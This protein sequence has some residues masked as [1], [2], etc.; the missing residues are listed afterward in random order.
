VRGGSKTITELIRVFLP[1]AAASGARRPSV[2]SS[3]L[4]EEAYNW[5]P[6][7]RVHRQKVDDVGPVVASLVTVAEQVR[8]DR[9]AVGPVVDQDPAEVIAGLRVKRSRMVRRSVSPSNGSAI[10]K[11]RSHGTPEQRERR[12]LQLQRSLGQG[13]YPAI[14][15]RWS[16]R[17]RHG[18]RGVLKTS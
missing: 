8:G 3:E 1:Y 17:R 11:R 2:G 7:F 9:I 5:P 13:H 12:R 15:H 4:R 18:S 16:L 10:V 14:A 6:R